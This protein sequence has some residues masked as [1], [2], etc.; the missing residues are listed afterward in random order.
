MSGTPP[1]P[2]GPPAGDPAPT[3]RSRYE[4]FD[5]ADVPAATPAPRRRT[6]TITVAAL[7]LAISGVLPLIT[8]FAFRPEGAAAIAFLVL[9]VAEIAGAALV[10]TLRPLGRPFGLALGCVGVV[11][12]IVSAAQSPAN[13]L[14]TIALNGF[15]IYALASSGAAFRR[16]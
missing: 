11:L 5:L 14:V 7:V 8:V 15:V 1:D 16:R 4:D 12:G 13:G 9:G 3:G 6:P 2:T 10:A